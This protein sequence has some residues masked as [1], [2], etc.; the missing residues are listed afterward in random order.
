MSVFITACVC[1]RFILLQVCVQMC[2]A[3]AVYLREGEDRDGVEAVT[4]IVESG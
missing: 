2:L 4:E 3:G 1:V